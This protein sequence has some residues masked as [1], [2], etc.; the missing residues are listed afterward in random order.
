MI[1]LALASAF[2][3][4]GGASRSAGSERAAEETLS[5]TSL[6]AASRSMPNSNSTFILLRPWLLEDVMFFTP[7]IPLMAFSSGSVICVSMISGLA[8]PYELLT[9]ILGGSIAG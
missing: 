1:G 8:P 3:I 6:A 2:E 7:A 4:T 9:L 5:L